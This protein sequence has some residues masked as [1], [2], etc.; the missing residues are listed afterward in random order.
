MEGGGFVTTGRMLR[1]ACIAA[2]LI[3]LMSSTTFAATASVDFSSSDDFYHNSYSVEFSS[4]SVGPLVTSTP[5]VLENTTNLVATPLMDTDTDEDGV[6]DDFS[7]SISEEVTATTSL[8]HCRQKVTVTDSTDEGWAVVVQSGIA[9]SATDVIS[10]SV[11]GELAGLDG[12]RGMIKVRWRDASGYLNG[13]ANDPS[14]SYFTTSG[15]WKKENLTAPTC[16]T[17][18]EIQLGLDVTDVGATGTVWLARAQVEKKARATPFTEGARTFAPLYTSTTA[19]SDLHGTSLMKDGDVYKMW[20]ETGARLGYAESDDLV[21]WRV[22]Y[23]TQ[24]LTTWTCEGPCVIKDGDTYRMW[25]HSGSR[26]YCASSPDGLTWTTENGGQYLFSLTGYYSTWARNPCVIKDAGAYKMWFEG[27]NG[28]KRYICYGTSDDGISWNIN[29][30]PVLSPVTGKFYE[31]YIYDPLVVLEGGTYRMLFGGGGNGRGIGYATSG[32]GT[33]WT[34]QNGTAAVMSKNNDDEHGASVLIEQGLTRCVISYSDSLYLMES[35]DWVVWATRSGG[36]PILQPLS[37]ALYDYGVNAPFVVYDGTQYVMY[38]TGFYDGGHSQILRTTSRDG[39]H[40]AEPASVFIDVD[41]GNYAY[42]PEFST[43]LT[44]ETGGT[45]SWFSAHDGVSGPSSIWFRDDEG[46]ITKAMGT[47][48]LSV[49]YPSVLKDGAIYKMWYAEVS[50]LNE[51]GKL[52]YAESPDGKTWTTKQSQLMAA[53]YSGFTSTSLGYPRVVKDGTL[54]RMWFTGS[55]LKVGYAESVDGQL[56]EV[57]NYG[58][59]ALAPTAGTYYAYRVTSPCVYKSGD[60]YLMWFGCRETSGGYDRIGYAEWTPRRCT[61]V[62]TKDAIDVAGWEEITSVAAS[63]DSAGADDIKLLFSADG[64]TSAMAYRD[65]EW[66]RYLVG[67]WDALQES[68]G[69]LF[70]YAMMPAEL[71]ALAPDDFAGLLE[72]GDSLQVAALFTPCD[73]RLPRLNSITFS[74]IAKPVTYLVNR[75]E[76]AST[77]WSDVTR[78]WTVLIQPQYAGARFFLSD[79]GGDHLK[80]YDGS[81]HSYTGG[82]WVEI[83]EGAATLYPDGM[84]RDEL[85]AL[86]AAT[87][88]SLLPSNDFAV[89]GIQRVYAS[90]SAGYRADFY[91]DCTEKFCLADHGEL[92]ITMTDGTTYTYTLDKADLQAFV[93]WVDLRAQGKGRPYFVVSLPL[94]GQYTRILCRIWYNQIVQFT[95]MEYN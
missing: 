1:I 78:V 44:G 68:A 50:A 61:A 70:E 15:C 83:Q 20:Y 85:E 48:E 31:D 42:G 29:A 9:V 71:K 60:K 64:Y 33:T 86:D 95:I 75:A 81:W 47:T 62:G 88:T 4:G 46:A 59:P 92:H 35:R 51:Y 25:F 13:G 5:A 76:Y 37:N 56:W 30:S 77:D 89:Y 65:G 91:V 67:G 94:E 6:A 55:S 22:A 69:E 53:Q 38:F 49:R 28:T 52:C 32:N 8:D 2:L 72:S 66:Q 23:G 12:A 36:E 11:D 57:K 73:D 39:M 90:S 54:Y 24:P 17:N 79:D 21:N 41:S 14:P 82:T 16:T 43:V 27:N 18:V 26:I 7:A 10:V 63:A 45:L 34:V 80:T 19:L 3:A 87:L 93:E 84:T 74:Y 58:A 40:W